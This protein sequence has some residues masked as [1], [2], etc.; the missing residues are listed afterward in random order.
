MN[1]MYS[2][3]MHC[4]AMNYASDLERLNAAFNR[5]RGPWPATLALA[6]ASARR[7]LGAIILTGLAT[8]ALGAGLKSLMPDSY[9]ST[10]QLLFDPRG[11]KIFTND[12]TVTN[13]D[14]NAAI[15]FVES[16]MGV[17]R[18][19]R[20]LSRVVDGE[21]AALSPDDGAVLAFARFC[22]G[23]QPGADY[24][25]ALQ[26]LYR[27]ISISR[28][29]R[30]YVV[31]V[32]VSEATPELA[33]R[34][35]RSVVKAYLDE[36]AATRAETT[37]A[38][39]TLLAGRLETLRQTLRLSE[40]KA[41]T[42]RRE[43]KLIRVGDK[44]MV[45]QQ[46]GVASAALADSRS[47]LDRVRARIKQLE[48]AP[49][50]AVALAG[51]GPEV[52]T[53]N[54]VAIAERRDAARVEVAALAGTLGARNPA[55]RDAR[56]KLAETERALGAE[57]AGVRAAALAELARATNENANLRATVA[58]LSTQA[59]SARQAEIPLGAISQEVDANRKLLNSFETRSR[60][61]GEFG[62]V[63]P[64]KVRVVSMARAPQAHR[65][66]LKM[67]L[68]SAIGFVIGV[69]VASAAFVFLA[70][71][72]AGAQ[73]SPGYAGDDAIKPQR[74]YA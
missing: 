26:A 69:L 35:A 44:L 52:D 64:E 54:L 15:A 73:D 38:L 48:K 53:R 51:F 20:V 45:E 42:Y 17:L 29:E 32:T 37:R 58:E 10:E 61:A 56:S 33:A 27:E 43:H 71:F 3:D 63:E 16:E 2:C 9:V 22:P 18:S 66:A 67:G 11:V 13:T 68:W 62:R 12:L 8:A 50:S 39:T 49:S 47:R 7:G 70:M 5:A 74:L 21:C 4:E 25:K 46:L 60:E 34:L 24:A 14:P 23:N 6:G 41:E 55:M 59:E 1:G 36:D 30:S 57:L 72:R 31:D 19:E 40:D 65:G 28:A